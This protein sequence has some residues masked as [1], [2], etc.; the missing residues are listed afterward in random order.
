MFYVFPWE[1]R[2]LMV[3]NRRAPLE[4]SLNLT[5]STDSTR[6]LGQL[7]RQAHGCSM[8]SLNDIN[9]A[10][11]GGSYGNICRAIFFADF[12]DVDH[13]IWYLIS[14]LLIVVIQNCS[15]YLKKCSCQFSLSWRSF[16]LFL[17]WLYMIIWHHFTHLRYF[18]SWQI[19]WEEYLQMFRQPTWIRT[20]NWSDGDGKG[21]GICI[22]DISLASS[23]CRSQHRQ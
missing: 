18:C 16:G 2:S 8:L 10:G 23:G 1:I 4:T 7:P 22:Y 14:L 3:W 20:E 6:R 12:R 15:N 13:R 11:R 5:G 19:P 21:N 9:V 17:F